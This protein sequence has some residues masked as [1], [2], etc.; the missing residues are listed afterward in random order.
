ME[1]SAPATSSPGSPSCT[2]TI[3]EPILRSVDLIRAE[4]LSGRAQAE[5]VVVDTLC[6]QNTVEPELEHDDVELCSSAP[7]EAATA[8]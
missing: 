3:D 6:E 2:S 8:G 5:R 4:P 1:S 7:Q